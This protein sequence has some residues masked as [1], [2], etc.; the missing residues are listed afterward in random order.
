[1]ALKKYLC[2]FLPTMS[3]LPA[4]PIKARPVRPRMKARHAIPARHQHPIFLLSQ[5]I[6]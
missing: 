1:M 5:K 2:E 4:G 6:M 3:S